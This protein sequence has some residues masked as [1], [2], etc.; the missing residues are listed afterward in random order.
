[1]GN[2][3]AGVGASCPSAV[4]CGG[5]WT[6]SGEDSFSSAAEGESRAASVESV[7]SQFKFIKGRGLPHSQ[8]GCLTTCSS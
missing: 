3:G 2:G 4:T 8:G 6:Q 1:M 5:G 7:K